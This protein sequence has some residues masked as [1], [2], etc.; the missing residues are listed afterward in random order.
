MLRAKLAHAPQKPLRMHDHPRRFVHREHEISGVLE[1]GV[2]Y[3]V[4]QMEAGA[5]GGL[6]YLAGW[7]IS[8]QAVPVPA[9]MTAV[10]IPAGRYAVFE[11]ALSE[12]ATAFD[13][14]L[15]SWLP[16]SGFSQTGSPMFER[17]G[18]DFDATVSSS[19]MEAHIPIVATGNASAA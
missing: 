3:G 6:S 1:R 18:A 14:M 19:W 17:Y 11:F 16:S 5:A 4:M 9:G 2:T 10:S 8:V 12:I 15:N 7:P 13:F